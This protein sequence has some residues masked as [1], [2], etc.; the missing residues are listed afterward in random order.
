MK[1]DQRSS[2]FTFA[3]K[4]D[5]NLIKFGVCNEIWLQ[6]EQIREW[7]LTETEKLAFAKKID[8]NR[9]NSRSRWKLTKAVWN[10]NWPKPN[11]F[12][13]AMKIDQKAE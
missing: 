12:A 1:I 4:I 2:K 3:T 6:T 7:K 5:Q 9:T 10:K 13:Y 11:E 8:Q